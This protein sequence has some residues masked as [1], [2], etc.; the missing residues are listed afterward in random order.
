MKRYPIRYSQMKLGYLLELLRQQNA[1]DKLIKEINK[2]LGELSINTLISKWLREKNI[3][4]K[5]L[6]EN[7]IA[8][9]FL[10]MYFI[11][12]IDKFPILEKY[13]EDVNSLDA[14]CILCNSQNKAVN[15]IAKEKYRIIFDS[16]LDD[17]D[18]DQNI[19][20]LYQTEGN[21]LEIETSSKK[22]IDFFEYKTSKIKT[23]EEGYKD[24]K[25]KSRNK[26]KKK[27]KR[28]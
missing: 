16:Y 27:I 1:N 8:E 14:I 13:L 21:D 12:N 18:L 4:V 11:K 9:K 25:L 23:P 15:S 5:E 6:L 10:L 28:R 26:I 20:I 3:I 24:N 2:K 22:V 17:L 7:A 19:K